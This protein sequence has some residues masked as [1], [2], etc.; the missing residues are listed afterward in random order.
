MI[1]DKGKDQRTNSEQANCSMA[2]GLRRLDVR[3]FSLLPA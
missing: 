2:P 3:G 1:L